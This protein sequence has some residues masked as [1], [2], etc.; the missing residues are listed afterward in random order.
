M[1]IP[2]WLQVV[3]REN[4]PLWATIAVIVLGSLILLSAYLKVNLL[5]WLQ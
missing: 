3:Y 1:K 4:G 2:D 5:E